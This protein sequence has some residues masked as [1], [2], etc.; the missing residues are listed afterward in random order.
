MPR[1]KRPRRLINRYAQSRLY[2]VETRSYVSMDRLK[3]LRSEGYEV[4]REVET[5]RFVS[6]EVLRPGFDA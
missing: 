1:K 4:V 2:D 3:E 6:E 5:G